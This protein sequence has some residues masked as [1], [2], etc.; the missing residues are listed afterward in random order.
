MALRRR[1]TRNAGRRGLVRR[2]PAGAIALALV[3]AGAAACDAGEPSPP[4][5]TA[6][7]TA[8][9]A[10]LTF[11]AFGPKDELTALGDVTG[12]F[13]ALYEPAN[14]KMETWPDEDSMIDAL[15]FGGDIPDVFMVSR[16][17]LAWLRD[18]KL[19]QPVDTL[20][21]E[22]GVDFGDVYSRDAVLA[23]SAETGCSACR[24]ASRR[25]SSTTTTTWSTS[26]GWRPAGCR[27]P[28]RSG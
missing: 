7:A 9:P 17:D 8:P 1:T 6:S 18:E 20:L 25:W 3:V 11:G 10:E 23:F 21:D 5:P 27:S 15:K 19:T 4:E 12:E 22:R 14:V 2:G 26:T 16:A 24:T 13:N 28:T